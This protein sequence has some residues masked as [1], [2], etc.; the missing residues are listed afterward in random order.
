MFVSYRKVSPVYQAIFMEEHAFYEIFC[1]SF[2]HVDF[3]WQSKSAVRSQFGQIINDIKVLL[4][5]ILQRNPQ[6]MDEFHFV[7]IDE[8][9]ARLH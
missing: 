4:M 8:G 6:S 3:L 2:A 7:A 5:R 1:L 9:M